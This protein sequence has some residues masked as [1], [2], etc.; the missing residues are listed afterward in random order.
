MREVCELSREA[1]WTS[2][3]SMWK[4]YIRVSGLKY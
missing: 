2:S 3:K 1:T 4:K